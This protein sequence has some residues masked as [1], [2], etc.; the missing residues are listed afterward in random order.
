[1]TAQESAISENAP[2]NAVATI[3]GWNRRIAANQRAA[4][5][6]VST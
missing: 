5:S 6:N 4:M 3:S 1:M 2:R